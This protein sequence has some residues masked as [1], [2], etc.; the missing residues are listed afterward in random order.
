LLQA[1]QA[2]S[3]V[4]PWSAT[5]PA[6][7]VAQCRALTLETLRVA[8]IVLQPVI[9][10]KAGELLDALDVPASQRTWKFSSLG[11]G[12]VGEVKAVKLFERF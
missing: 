6:D 12:P 5:T 10:G 8:G 7:D 2:V 3:T 1:N 9:P 4:A 11:A